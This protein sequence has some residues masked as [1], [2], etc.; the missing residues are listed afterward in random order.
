M[1]MRM[2]DLINSDVEYQMPRNILLILI[3]VPNKF[4]VS[5]ILF[6][7]YHTGVKSNLEKPNT[8][9][10]VFVLIYKQ[11]YK[12]HSVGPTYTRTFFMGGVT[13]TT[14]KIA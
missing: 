12:T 6:P 10:S 3:I 8:V 7:F 5:N 1:P 11:S 9:M 4:Y 13:S 14:I 2:W